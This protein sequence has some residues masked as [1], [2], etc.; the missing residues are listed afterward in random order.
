MKITLLPQIFTKDSGAL[1]SIAYTPTND[2]ANM[3]YQFSTE[4]VPA[5][6]PTST[7]KTCFVGLIGAAVCILICLLFFVYIVMDDYRRHSIM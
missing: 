4:S 6:M 3:L 7:I 2:L 1:S 5:A